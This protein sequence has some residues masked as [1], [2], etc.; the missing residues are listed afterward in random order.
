MIVETIFARPGVG[1]LAVE[2]IFNRDYPVIQGY[3][4][5]MALVFLVANLVVDI[6]YCFLDPRIKLGFQKNDRQNIF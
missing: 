6:L 2:S 5:F 1:R 4:L 3:V